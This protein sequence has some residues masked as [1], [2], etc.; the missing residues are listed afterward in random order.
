MVPV[1]EF[2]NILI[3]L[4]ETFRLNGNREFEEPNLF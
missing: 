2:R 3:P 4:C 1:G